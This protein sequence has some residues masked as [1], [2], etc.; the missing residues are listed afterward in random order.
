MTCACS[1]ARILQ[2]PLAQQTSQGWVSA[3]SWCEHTHRNAPSPGTEQGCPISLQC[4]RTHTSLYNTL[5]TRWSTNICF[6]ANI[7][8]F[9]AWFRSNLEPPNSPAAFPRA[10]SQV[11]DQNSLGAAGRLPGGRHKGCCV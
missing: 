7:C 5:G 9:S 3:V 11:C 2:K 8:F 4:C 10:D 1:R 6:L